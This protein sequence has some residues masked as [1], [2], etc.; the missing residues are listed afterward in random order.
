MPS[1]QLA[2]K[3]IAHAIRIS[4][5][6]Q[7]GRL[8]CSTK[9]SE[10]KACRIVMCIL[11]GSV[12]QVDETLTS[13]EDPPPEGS[14]SD[15]NSGNEDT[16]PAG[17]MELFNAKLCSI[18]SG[19]ASSRSTAA[20]RTA[21][22]SHSAE[23]S[24]DDTRESSHDDRRSLSAKHND[25]DD[26]GK[27]EHNDRKDHGKEEHSDKDDRD[28]RDEHNGKDELN[29]KKNGRASLS[30]DASAGDHSMSSD[31]SDKSAQS[32]GKGEQKSN[33][34]STSQ[35][36]AG[37]GTKHASEEIDQSA[38]KSAGKSQ[39]NSG[40]K[41]A[42]G[43]SQSVQLMSDEE[44]TLSEGGTEKPDEPDEILL[45]E[46]TFSRE[47]ILQ[48]KTPGKEGTAENAALD[49]SGMK[50]VAAMKDDRAM[51]VFIRRVADSCSIKITQEGG[52]NGLVGYFVNKP[53]GDQATMKELKEALFKALLAESK[54][55]W[56]D[57]KSDTDTTGDT[58]PLDMIGYCK[59][60][61]LRKSREMIRFVR[62][63]VNNMGIKITDNG[64]F[65]GMMSFYSEP[66][67]SGSF[68]RLMSEIKRAA[69]E[70]SW[71]ELE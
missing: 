60:R 33:S 17:A 67:D 14:D 54:H 69:Y 6:L 38:G 49:E 37:S 43:G 15:K 40:A 25:T 13:S 30:K 59:V 71:A 7:E 27:D 50:D 24:H 12:I 45:P 62:R 68:M 44:E 53:N 39:L 70:H 61:A 51:K 41:D 35:N 1:L 31:K 34:K 58:A 18:K 55:H 29:D 46:Q 22:S 42:N 48:W 57:V 56:A 63:M 5:Y 32:S 65:D 20:S 66:D 10:S 11:F 26:N 28:D 19:S 47:F 21:S 3:Q 8:S 64:G 16:L 36:Q 9:H 2:T 52:L 23:S 4:H